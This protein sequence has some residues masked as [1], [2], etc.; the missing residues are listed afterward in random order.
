MMP[1]QQAYL[2][3]IADLLL[4]NSYFYLYCER[5]FVV[6]K[7]IAFHYYLGSS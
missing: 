1:H 5:I 2:I 6:K 7:Y 4:E 3:L